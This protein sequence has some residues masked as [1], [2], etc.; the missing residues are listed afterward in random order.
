MDVLLNLNSMILYQYIRNAILIG[1]DI[2]AYINK[3]ISCYVIAIK[4]IYS[5]PD[6]EQVPP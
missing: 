5:V 3:Y 2:P 4:V 1:D 6:L